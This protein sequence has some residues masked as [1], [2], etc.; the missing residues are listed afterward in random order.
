MTSSFFMLPLLQRLRL[1]DQIFKHASLTRRNTVSFMPSLQQQSTYDSLNRRERFVFYSFFEYCILDSFLSHKFVPHWISLIGSIHNFNTTLMQALPRTDS[2]QIM[3]IPNISF[4]PIFKVA[5]DTYCLP[6][7]Y[8][9]TLAFSSLPKSQTTR[10]MDIP[11][12]YE[13]FHTPTHI[14]SPSVLNFPILDDFVSRRTI[15]LIRITRSGVMPMVYSFQKSTFIP[16][17]H[18]N[19]TSHIKQ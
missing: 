15:Y 5:Y 19:S 17:G 6:M 10:K 12:I 8:H 18:I 4:C 16:I 3:I 7:F 1:S 13:I 9:I 14:T 2:Q 11:S